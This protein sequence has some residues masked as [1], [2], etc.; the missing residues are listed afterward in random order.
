MRAALLAATALWPI[1]AF[2]Q[3]I[4][5]GTAQTVMGNQRS[6]VPGGECAASSPCQSQGLVPITF[7]QGD[8]VLQ[9][10]ITD[11]QGNTWSLQPD[12]CNGNSPG[13]WWS[14]VYLNG[15]QVAC[16]YTVA[17]RNVGGVVWEEEAKGSGWQPVTNMTL[18]EGM[19][20][21]YVADPGQGTGGNPTTSAPVLSGTVADI[22]ATTTSPTTDPNAP[23]QEAGAVTPNNGT[24]TANGNTYS[25]DATDGD[26]ASINGA[27]INQG[28]YETSQLIQGSDGA[29]YGQSN[30]AS[31][32]GQWF[33]LQ[34]TGGDTW[35]Q[36]LSGTPAAVTSGGS[37]TATQMATS[38]G[39]VV[40]PTT[41]SIQAQISTDNQEIQQLMAQIH[42]Y[43]TA[44]TTTTPAATTT[45]VT[46]APAD[47]TSSGGSDGG[48]G[49]GGGEAQ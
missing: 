16:G 24:F 27:P 6:Q 40:C 37:S 10:S 47:S 20:G 1:T 5:Q 15:Q 29:I 18:G 3:Q 32:N 28:A 42:T 33:Q 23:C 30:A 4:D 48:D 9:G 19:V 46:P 25:I 39:P 44:P 22:A 36:P 34:G 26:V 21:P 43:Q 7:Q 35:W 2:G 49:G 14:G 45:T 31:N 12:S 41:P 38:A 8:V 11:A 17:L 13:N